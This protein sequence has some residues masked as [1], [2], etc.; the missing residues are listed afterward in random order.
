M[1]YEYQKPDRMSNARVSNPSVDVCVLCEP[2]L[3]GTSAL[4]GSS[5]HNHK[6]E[7][8]GEV[9]EIMLDVHTGQVSYA[10]LSFGGF[11]GMWEKL[12][13]VPWDALTLEPKQG[14][15]I[16]QVEMDRL[17]QARGFDK[18]KWPSTTDSLWLQGIRP[19]DRANL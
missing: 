13:A 11:L 1:I 19:Y 3:M 6:G 18:K 17:K 14:L 5:V 15:V 4:V 7:D 8:L 10:V 16:L 12:F 2:S 9:R